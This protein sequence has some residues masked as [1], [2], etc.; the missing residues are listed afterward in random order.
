VR[1]VVSAVRDF[2]AFVDLGGVEGLL[3]RSEIGH[4]RSQAVADAVSGESSP[5]WRVPS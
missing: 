5:S 1:G 3:P 2:G 4:D